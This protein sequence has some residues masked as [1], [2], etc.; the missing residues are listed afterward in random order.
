MSALAASFAVLL[1]LIDYRFY[2]PVGIN[3]PSTFLIGLYTQPLGF[4][5]L[6]AWLVLY[7][8]ERRA[9]WRFTLTCLLLALT[10][11]ANFFNALAA[12]IFVATTV[13][14]D[15]VKL[16]RAS[17]PDS[18]KKI[19]TR[20][21]FHATVPLVAVCLTLFWL[22]PMLSQYTYFVTRP[23]T[24]SATQMASPASWLWYLLSAVGVVCWLKQPT[25]AMWPF[26]TTCLILA[27]GVVFATTAAPGWFPL[28][29]VRLLSTLNFLLALPVG[30]ALLAGLQLLTSKFNTALGRS[31]LCANGTVGV[32][33]ADA[34]LSSPLNVAVATVLLAA[35]FVLIKPPS[36]TL[37]FLPAQG[38]A[39]IDGVLRFA[40]QHRDGRYLVEVPDFAYG[41]AALDGRAINS[42]LGAQ[43]NE[44]MS[45][46][47]REASPHALFFNPLVTAFSAFPDN[48]G[49]SSVLADDLDFIEQPLARHLER[50]R[51]VG[52]KYLVIVSPEV[53]SRLAQ[54]PRI[55][56][57]YDLGS[58]SI[59]ELRDEPP[60][61]VRSLSYRPALVVSSFSL[62]QRRRNEYNFI[63]W[64]EEQFADGWF[65]V[66]LA[67][68]PESKVDQLRGLEQFGALI[69]DTYDYDDENSAFEQLQNFSR[70]RALVL[71]SSDAPLFRRIQ[72]HLPEFPLATIVERA[73]EPSGELLRFDTPSY[74]YGNSSI[75]RAWREIRQ[76][77]DKSK[78]PVEESSLAARTDREEISITPNESLDESVPTLI[79]TTYHPSWQRTDHQPIYSV[80][81]FFMLTFIQRP[82]QIVYARRWYD[83]LGVL[84][85]TSSFAFL[86]VHTLWR[87]RHAN[88]EY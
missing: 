21:S 18:R 45:V 88:Y 65:D 57:R 19:L 41:A 69:L 4:I 52:V 50:A 81:P 64:S 51:F 30:R 44:T 2:Y 5:L 85:S 34:I 77:L 15:A 14:F 67:R 61:R 62:K 42:Y 68:S 20:L 29:S 37:S 10:I 28:Q 46:V 87:Y 11:L 9:Y 13:L 58:W 25:R 48:F 75:R 82:A 84:C 55:K 47:F 70:H 26:L 76:A 66:L 78:V 80:T 33:D 23:H 53:R 40:Q 39:L 59:F 1:P 24:P 54:E 31:H 72:S 8:D 74:R 16:Y 86:C 35:A 73:P 22:V 79:E 43:G 38:R 63:R 6:A 17:E 36:Y 83:W 71:L 32:R 7:L 60:A 49:V 3:N 12:A 27:G 56:A